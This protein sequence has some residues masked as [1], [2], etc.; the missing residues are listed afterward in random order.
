M[1]NKTK[2]NKNKMQTKIKS[3]EKKINQLKVPPDNSVEK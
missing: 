3:E 1:K 2:Q